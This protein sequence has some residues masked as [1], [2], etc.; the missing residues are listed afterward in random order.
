VI[1]TQHGCDYALKLAQENI[2]RT[3]HVRECSPE[4]P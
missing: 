3:E 1:R 4:Q 2:L